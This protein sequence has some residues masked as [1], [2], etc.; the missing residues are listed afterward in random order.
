M[1]WPERFEERLHIIAHG[2]RF[3]VDV[4]LTKSTLR[5]D[6]VWRREAPLTSG[7]EFFLGDGRAI[8]LRDQEHMAITYLKAHRDELRAIAEFPGVDAFIL[9]LVY[10]AKLDGSVSGV[11]L[12]CS[13][14]LMLPALDIGITPIH[15]VTYD[16]PSNPEDEREPNAY[17]YLAGAFNPD[18]ITRR[19]GVTPSETARA[20]DAIGSAGIK[21]QNSLWALHSRLQP[22]APVDLHV[23]DVLDQLDTNRL[24]FEELSREIGGIIEIVGFSREYPQFLSNETLSGAWR[25]MPL[26]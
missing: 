22:S 19:V 6:F 23:G 4:F 12:D 14:E 8:R 1:V 15:Y 10:I 21:K 11:A 18:E 5:P 7:V 2:E 13:R 17:F 26:G 3:D 24:A 25:S 9:G 20:G 16:R